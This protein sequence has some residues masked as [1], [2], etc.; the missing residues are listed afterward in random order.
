MTTC[1]QPSLVSTVVFHCIHQVYV[2]LLEPLC[3]FPFDTF[4]LEGF[5]FVDL[6]ELQVCTV[7]PFGVAVFLIQL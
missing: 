5:V 7:F 6:F 2:D 4:V 1:Y 3:S